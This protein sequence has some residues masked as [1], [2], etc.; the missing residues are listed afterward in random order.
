[1][2]DQDAAPMVGDEWATWGRTD[3]EGEAP[4]RWKPSGNVGALVQ[5]TIRG[6]KMVAGTTYGDWEFISADVDVVRPDGKG[7][8]SFPETELSGVWFLGK[9]KAAPSGYRALGVITQETYAK[10]T[11]YAMRSLTPEER[12]L[13]SK[14]LPTY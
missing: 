12:E 14:V 1:M 4:E 8:D 3:L 5:L 11:G 10:G 2:T 13:A 6:Y 9:F 7:Y